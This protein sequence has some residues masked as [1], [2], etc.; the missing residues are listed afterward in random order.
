MNKTRESDD[1]L[2]VVKILEKKYSERVGAERFNNVD[3][4]NAV[5]N[6]SVSRRDAFRSLK[7]A[8]GRSRNT[9]RRA[10]HLGELAFESGRVKPF[11]GVRK[12]HFIMMGLSNNYFSEK[13]Q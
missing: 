10:M 5:E 11:V 8:T 4:Q 3:L 1:H 2:N 9:L 7:G 6:T 12:W 13:N